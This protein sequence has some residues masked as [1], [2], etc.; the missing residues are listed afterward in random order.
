MGC[1]Q[2]IGELDLAK[3]TGRDFEHGLVPLVSGRR[4]V[5]PWHRHDP[6]VQ[7]G[8]GM[9]IMVTIPVAA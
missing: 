8:S 3:P 9:G 5:A 6:A 2:S 1:K 4:Q 7:P